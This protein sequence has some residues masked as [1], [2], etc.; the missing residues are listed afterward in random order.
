LVI[1]PSISSSNEN[2]ISINLHKL[3]IFGNKSTL[4]KKKSVIKCKI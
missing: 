2:R 1:L 4:Q 3:S